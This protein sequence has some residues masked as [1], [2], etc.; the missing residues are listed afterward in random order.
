[1]KSKK[2]IGPIVATS[3]LV[4]VCIVSL[5]AFENWYNEYSTGLNSKIE[6]KTSDMGSISVNY[7]GADNSG[8][9]LYVK[10]SGKTYALINE[11]KIN[12]Q[13]CNLTSSDVIG[14][15][16][17]TQVNVDCKTQKNDHVEVVFITDL[18]VF[19]SEHIVR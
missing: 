6:G 5:V 4:V 15:E 13:K 3:L 16:T 9:I 18:G 10:N 17:L 12:K 19:S 1:M 11:V 7:V 14:E 8:T 2:S